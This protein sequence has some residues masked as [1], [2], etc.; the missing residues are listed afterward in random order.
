MK[1]AGQYPQDL[2][3]HSFHY[4]IIECFRSSLVHSVFK[5]LK[6]LLE[7]KLDMCYQ[8]KRGEKDMKFNE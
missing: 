8:E 6:I 4:V 5:K 3:C 1:I 2:I 7:E